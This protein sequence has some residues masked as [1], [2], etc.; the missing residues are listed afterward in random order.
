MDVAAI[1]QLPFIAFML[2]LGGGGI[3]LLMRGKL[4]LEREVTDRDKAIIEWKT[5][6][7]TATGTAAQQAEQIKTMSEQIRTLTDQVKTLMARP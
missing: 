7:T 1:A 6:A 2:V 4:R 3:G 5:I